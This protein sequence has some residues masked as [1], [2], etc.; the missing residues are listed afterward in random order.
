MSRECLGS[1]AFC[2]EPCQIWKIVVVATASKPR[3]RPGALSCTCVREIW[4][5]M[6]RYGEQHLRVEDADMRA[7]GGEGGGGLG[8]GGLGG[9]GGRALQ[10]ELPGAV[11]EPSETASL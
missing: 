4:G 10:K 7:G 1:V 9:G 3:T 11:Q 5:D 6:G 2:L 8:G